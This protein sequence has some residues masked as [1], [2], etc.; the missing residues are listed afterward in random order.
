MLFFGVSPTLPIQRV[1]LNEALTPHGV[2][3]LLLLRG[4]TLW[5][6]INGLRFKTPSSGVEW[7]VNLG[8]K[9]SA[10]NNPEKV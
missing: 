4:L 6:L 3:P 9:F 5:T 8:A 7:C 10:T 1:P 2:G